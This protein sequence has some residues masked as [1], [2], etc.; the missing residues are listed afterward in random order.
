MPPKKKKAKR[1]KSDDDEPAPREVKRRKD[2]PDCA[3]I[4]INFD[5]ETEQMI[6]HDCGVIFAEL[7][8]KFGRKDDELDFL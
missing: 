6:C 4:N 7:P 2:C 3:S 8:E 5:P 1:A